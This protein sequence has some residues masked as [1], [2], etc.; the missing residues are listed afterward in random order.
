MNDGDKQTYLQRY[1]ERLNEFGDDPKTLGWGGGIERQNLRFKILSEIGVSGKDSVLDIGCGFADLF[2]YLSTVGWKGVYL[3]VDINGDLLEVASKKYEKATLKQIDILESN[4]AE[5]YDWVLSSGV[6][7]AKLDFE[8][9][10]IY[11][12]KMLRRMFQSAKKGVA[13]DFMSTY[14]DFQHPIAFH[15]NPADAIDMGKKLTDKLVLRM[16]YL[17]Y[18]YC[19]YL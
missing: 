8:D 2:G 16:D 3:G 18:E 13:C 6:F 15:L 9:N 1:G 14:V 10:L 19:I 12:E 17:P 5:Q 7:N 4:L 11:I